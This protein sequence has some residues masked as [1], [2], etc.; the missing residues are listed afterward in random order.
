V[1]STIEKKF[2]IKNDEHFTKNRFFNPSQIRL[3]V[4]SK[5]AMENV[6]DI[7]GITQAF[8]NYIEGEINFDILDDNDLNDIATSNR[9]GFDL[10]DKRMQKMIQI[11]RPLVNS[12]IKDRLELSED[13]KEKE[14]DFHNKIQT[15]A[16]KEYIEAIKKDFSEI[17]E[18]IQTINRSVI[19]DYPTVKI[20]FNILQQNFDE[21]NM[22]MI[23]GINGDLV[24]DSASAKT[25]Y[26]LFFS[27]K[28][29][30]DLFL[31]HFIYRVLTE[32]RGI[33]EN[34][35]FYQYQKNNDIDRYKFL[36]KQI[37]D[38]IRDVN[39]KVIYFTTDKFNESE[40]S[41]FEGGAG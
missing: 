40:F 18:K 35:I 28:S 27:Y 20:D 36:D 15:N 29:G 4:R 32:L 38:C 6:L 25:H 8:L 34:E 9:Q 3:Y 37:L 5:L 17:K 21:I 26:K 1:H 31:S 7:L 39:T 23:N 41:L 19:K 14:K 24:K 11:L 22:S 2:A 33:Q 30:N 12:L 13:I 16:K 10:S